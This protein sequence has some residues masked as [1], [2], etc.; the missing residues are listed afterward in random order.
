MALNQLTDTRVRN[1]KGREREYLLTDGEGLF[2]RVRP[3]GA[4]SWV[5]YFSLDGK[6]RKRGLGAYPNVGLSVA[7]ELATGCRE[8]V[9]KGVDPVEAERAAATERRAERIRQA[10][11]HTVKT[12]FEEWVRREL[13]ARRRD[14]GAQVREYFERDVARRIGDRFASEI[15]RRDIQG[16]IDAIA[17][18]GA[19]RSANIVRAILRQLFG[20]ALDREIII[21]DPTARV[22]KLEGADKERTRVLS[23]DE[24]RELAEKLPASGLAPGYHAAVW[25]LLATCARIGELTR[26]K[27]ADIDLEAGTWTI[28]AANSK[29]GREHLIH[30]SVFAREHFE[31]LP[32]FADCVWLFPGRD[33]RSA[34][35]KKAIPIQLYDRMR[36]TPRKSRTPLAGTLLLS[37]GSWT[38]HDLRRTGATLMGEMGIR[39][40]VIDRCLNHIEARK[41]TRT[42]QRQELLDDRR[43][44]FQRLG[45][46]LTTI[47]STEPGKVA[48][49]PAERRA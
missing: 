37:G 22:R 27:W 3:D 35:N 6:Q 2:L 17:E 1:A 9:A 25:I 45:E 39:P 31:H 20:Y 7:R 32:R 42:Y 14:Q 23:P 34:V 18:R 33:G 8:Q 11:C 49:F 4:K 29:N 44:A 26:A 16:I 13:H 47:L 21:A 38:A 15:T 41:V 43:R 19:R 40:D 30:L 46:C 28:P 36:T 48:I 12:L 24:I 10:A 5:F